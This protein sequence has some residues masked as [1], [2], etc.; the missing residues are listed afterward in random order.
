MNTS[1]QRQLIEYLILGNTKEI[2]KNKE[3]PG[4]N[5]LP[6]LGFTQLTTFSIGAI[7]FPMVLEEGW[8]SIK[9]SERS[10]YRGR[11][12]VFLQHYTR[13]KDDQLQQNYRLHHTMKVEIPSP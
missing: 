4:E 10:I 3:E 11:R 5:R 6:L 2:G 7:N 12:P 8:K 1:G 13:T 9:V